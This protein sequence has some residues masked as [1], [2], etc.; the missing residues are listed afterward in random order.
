MKWSLPCL[1]VLFC[2][3]FG[4]RHHN[5]TG[6]LVPDA[7]LFGHWVGSWPCT[8]CD[9]LAYKLTIQR[10]GLFREEMI[11]V[12]GNKSIELT[13]EGTWELLNDSVLLIKKMDGTS[14][15][16]LSKINRLG[17]LNDSGSVK[18]QYV[19]YKSRAEV[20]LKKEEELRKM[21]IDFVTRHD[22]PWR[23]TID[24][25]KEVVFYFPDG[26][27]VRVNLNDAIHPDFNR[28]QFSRSGPDFSLSIELSKEVCLDSALGEP[29]PYRVELSAEKKGRKQ[30][31]R[32]VGCGSFLG[33]WRLHDI[34]ALRTLNGKVIEAASFDKGIPYLEFNVREGKIYGNA[35]CNSISG[36]FIQNKNTIAIGAIASTKM[37]CN[38]YAFEQSFLTALAR[39]NLRYSFDG[40]KLTLSDDTDELVFSKVD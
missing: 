22:E 26:E 4:C 27:E 9:V 32:F 39:K 24:F 35:G 3:F 12:N 18:D 13:T 1:V 2:T 8:D 30:V 36:S 21:G 17:L 6:P 11:R 16:F 37:L 15:K 31:S 28:W 38:A 14:A 7:E 23:L 25:E 20:K 34:W 5:G 29:L 33:D 10:P 40:L 19:L